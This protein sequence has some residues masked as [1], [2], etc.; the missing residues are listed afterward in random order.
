MVEVL[1][2]NGSAGIVFDTGFTNRWTFEIFAKVVN[3]SF[4]VIRLC[5]EMGNP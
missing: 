3:I 5:V 2:G 1:I 4:H